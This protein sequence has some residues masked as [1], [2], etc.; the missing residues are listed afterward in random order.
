VSL[1]DSL[2]ALGVDLTGWELRG[3]TGVS[4]DGRIVVGWGRN[5]QGEFEAW[6]AV[7]S[8]GAARWINP[9]GGAYD[10]AAN[11]STNAVPGPDDAVTFDLPG[12]YTVTGTAFARGRSGGREAERLLADDGTVDFALD[13]LALT[14]PDSLRPSLDVSGDATAK[15]VTGSATM[16]DAVVSAG[17]PN[18]GGGTATLQVFNTGTTLIGTRTVRL[19]IDGGAG[20]LFVAGGL[21]RSARGHV[22]D[23][24]PQGGM[25]GATV[26]NGGTWDATDYLV[27]G[28]TSTGDLRVE[29]GGG[30][31]TGE[32]FVSGFTPS[33]GTVMVTGTGADGTP[34]RLFASGNLRVGNVGRGTLHVENGGAVT[35]ALIEMGRVGGIPGVDDWATVN[36]DGEGATGAPSL[37][38][39]QS[40]GVG[41][42]GDAVL[43]VLDGGQVEANALFV[44][45]IGRGFLVVLN[46]APPPSTSTVA[47]TN[48]DFT[49]TCTV[50]LNG[51]DDNFV[52][53][54]GRSYV[55]C[56]EVILFASEVQLLRSQNDAPLLFVRG[57]IDVQSAGLLTLSGGIAD[58]SSE[59]PDDP[60]I[61]VA[62]RVAGE[63]TLAG[64]VR[65]EPGGVIE[66]G[67]SCQP[68]CP[69]ASAAARRIPGVE[70]AFTGGSDGPGG[71]L[72]VEGRLAVDPG[73]TLAV[74]LAGAD[75]T[76]QGRLRVRPVAG[77]PAL[78]GSATLGGTLRLAFSNAYA[79]H[80]GDT[81][82]L[83]DAVSTTGAF[84]ATEFT[85]LEPGWQFTVAA[86]NGAVVLTSLS[87]GVATTF[88]VPAEPGA[89][90]PPAAFA[91]SAPYPNPSTGTATLDLDVP[92]TGHA[93]VAVYD[94]LGRRVAVLLDAE[95]AAGTHALRF[96]AGGLPSGIYLVRAVTAEGAQTRSV[97][98]VR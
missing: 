73:A 89:P 83:I 39:A 14:S 41:V 33:E 29:A 42:T 22:G 62:G 2:V 12:T 49:G 26:G 15:I 91:L 27:V 38:V 56:D 78:D 54:I 96:E 87:D 92:T 21:L 95:V 3:A 85:G 76:R 37:L 60:D 75:S 35:A 44:G 51:R 8:D 16:V 65:V 4:A 46:D 30:V 67:I 24:G 90:A 9:A 61:R 13:H 77:Q 52:M 97:T 1:P 57:Q 58:A 23:A 36:V 79:P 20:N 50:G 25:S 64:A 71:T 18:R 88:P 53:V 43:N 7:L 45:P 31:T 72:R 63:G 80:T 59:P 47:V 84:A 40:V 94:A 34:S 98:L 86:Q 19:G 32:F 10:L 82:E 70:A 5:P 17:G 28:A 11:W 81:F 6:R 55:Y 74:V 69:R 48:G 93:S 66:A 68:T